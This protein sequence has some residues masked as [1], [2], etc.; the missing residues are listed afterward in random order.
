[1]SGVFLEVI[2]FSFISEYISK[3]LGTQKEM[4]GYILMKNYMAMIT[5]NLMVW[6]KTHDKF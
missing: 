5:N 6:G 2:G 3:G 4:L 1:M